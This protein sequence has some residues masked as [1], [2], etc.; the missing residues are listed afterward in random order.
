MIRAAGGGEQ[1]RDNFSRGA[2]ALGNLPYWRVEH[3]ADILADWESCLFERY[4]K[5]L[6]SAGRL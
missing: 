1:W 4:E 2:R 6:R 3:F 5:E